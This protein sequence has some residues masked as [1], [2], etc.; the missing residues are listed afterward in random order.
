MESNK[1]SLY[2]TITWYIAHI[3]MATSVAF[4]ITGSFK[5]AATIASL[6]IIWEAGLFYLH[7]RAWSKFGYRI[8]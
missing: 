3:V 7:E 5:V 1:R 2:K 4:F 8:K 6:E